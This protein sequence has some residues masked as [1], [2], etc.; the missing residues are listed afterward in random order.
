VR[1]LMEHLHASAPWG[2]EVVTAPV[3]TGDAFMGKTDG[4]VFAAAR[5]AAAEAFDTEPKVTG[6]GGT[7]PLLTTLQRLAPDAEFVIWGPGDER[8]QVHAANESLDLGELERMIVA[9]TLLLEKLGES[10][11]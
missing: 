5:E 8:S 7:I 10:Q 6:S 9:E 3:H 1:L 2:V 11:A 4:P